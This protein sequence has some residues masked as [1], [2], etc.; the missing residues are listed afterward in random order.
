MASLASPM[1]FSL[2]LFRNHSPGFASAGRSDYAAP[3]NA[4][5][6]E[7]DRERHSSNIECRHVVIVSLCCH[8][9]SSPASASTAVAAY[10]RALRH[11]TRGERVEYR[12]CT[13]IARRRLLD[14]MTHRTERTNEPG[15]AA[16]EQ[17]DRR[18]K[19]DN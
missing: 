6:R 3:T 11:G 4:K 18:S 2:W 10:V 14:K 17:K 15:D 12:C 1:R 9:H 16:N 13:I 19:H 8:S 7:R 5:E